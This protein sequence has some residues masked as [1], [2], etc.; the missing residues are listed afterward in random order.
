MQLWIVFGFGIANFY[1]H[2]AVMEG[3][4]PMFAEIAATIRRI[5]GRWGGYALEFVLLVG[6]L[7]FARRGGAAAAIVYG[8]Y[9]VLNVAGYYMIRV[10]ERR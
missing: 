8:G 5:G 3:D 7:W 2:R 6:A 1:M 4:G 10:L 9:T